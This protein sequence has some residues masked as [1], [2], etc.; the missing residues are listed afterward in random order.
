VCGL[1]SAAQMSTHLNIGISDYIGIVPTSEFD[2]AE[3]VEKGLPTDSL[4]LL[5]QKGLT[6]SELSEIVISPRTLKHR[7]AR[8]ENLSHEETDR[9]VRVAR[10]VSLAENV[11]GDQGKALLWLRTEDDRIGNRTPLSMLQTDAGGRLIESMLW[12]IDE[13]VYI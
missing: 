5:K 7:K 11:S 8:G 10:I 4:A 1:M 2:L 12:Q 3:I 9:V 13:G 6:F